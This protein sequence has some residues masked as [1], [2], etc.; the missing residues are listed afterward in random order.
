MAKAMLWQTIPWDGNTNDKRFYLSGNTSSI[1][2]M[3]ITLEC[4][5]HLSK[6]EMGKQLNAF[7]EC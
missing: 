4:F 6:V 3:R 1:V 7:I 2:N 5:H